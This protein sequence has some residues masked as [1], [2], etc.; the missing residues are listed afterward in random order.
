MTSDPG[1]PQKDAQGDATMDATG[2]ATGD[3]AAGD[4]TAVGRPVPEERKPPD[5]M[6]FITSIGSPIALGTALLFWC[7]LVP[8]VV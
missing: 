7:H 3:A 8:I 4:A 2:G 6:K 5:L 1:Q